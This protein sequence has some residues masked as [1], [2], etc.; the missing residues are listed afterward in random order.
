MKII[1]THFCL[2][3]FIC[4]CQHNQKS[5]ENSKKDTVPVTSDNS[6]AVKATNDYR[7][8]WHEEFNENGR[9]NPEKWEFEKGFKRNRELQWYQEVNA[10]CKDGSLFIEA[11]RENKLNPN[12][13]AQSKKW[14]NKRKNIYYTSSCITS[15]QSWKYGRF[16][17]RARLKADKGLWPAIWFLGTEGQWP[18]NGEIDLMEY[19]NDMILANACWGT[20]QAYKAKWDSSKTPYQDFKDPNWDQKFHVWR[21]DWNKNS[22]KL[23]LDDQLLNSIDLQK[24]INPDSS[25]GPKEPFQQKHYLLLNLAI[26][27]TNGGDPSETRFPNHFEI[28]YVRIYQKNSN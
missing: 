18:S 5:D 19:Y 2:L 27:G 16:E 17:I 12:F 14:Q 22:I 3:L 9:P 4:S 13:I 7:L 26:G 15:K 1:L 6:I 10:F 20:K 11:R 21:M 28:D 25:R 8:V 23:Y 24:A